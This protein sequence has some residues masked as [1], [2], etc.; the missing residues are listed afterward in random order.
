ML[1]FENRVQAGRRLGAA[2]ECYSSNSEVTVLALA[3]GGLPV[4]E[5]MA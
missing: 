4:G 3:R 2:L 5:Q 1:P